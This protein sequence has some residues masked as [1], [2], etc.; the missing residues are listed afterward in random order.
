[1]NEAERWGVT[2]PYGRGRRPVLL[3][4]N[5]DGRVDLYVT[6][7]GPR[8]D[9]RRSENILYLNAEDKF[10]EHP[11]TAAGPQGSGCVVTGDWANDGTQDLLACGSE[12]Q[13]YTNIALGQ[14]ELRNWLLGTPVPWPRDA[15]LED[16][17][18]DGWL[19]LVIVGKRELQIRLNLRSGPR[20]SV[21]HHRTALVDGMSV[22]VGDLT[23]DALPDVYV[24]QGH[25]GTQNATDVLLAGPAWMPV[26][27]PQAATGTGDTVEFMTILGRPTAVVTNGHDYSRGPVQFISFQE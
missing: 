24:V 5:G 26:P 17:N 4:F 12:L 22:A 6:N 20:F 3:N 10:V 2:D 19:D 8:S 25:D 16:L 9:G 7:W 14:T 18:G 1:V 13:L 15:E 11:V 21:V 23:G 27:A